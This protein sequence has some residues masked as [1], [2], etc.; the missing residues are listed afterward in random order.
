LQTRVIKVRYAE[1]KLLEKNARFMKGAMFEQLVKN[2]QRDG[3]LTSLPVVNRQSGKLEVASG[4][5]RVAAAIKAGLVEGDA[6]E[7][8]TPLTRE[9]FVAIQL[10]HNAIAGEDDP[11]VLRALYDE[12]GFDWKEYSGLSDD[13]FDVNNLDTSVLRV[14]QP[15][16]EELHVSFL[17]GDAEV[18]KRWLE[19]I[20]K[21]KS[22]ATRYVG[23]Y[24]DFRLFFETLVDVKDARGVVNTAVALRMMAELAGQALEKNEREA[25]PSRLGQQSEKS[26]NART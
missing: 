18:F 7:I 23:L 15:F 1:L 17:P 26:A 22:A 6:L 8:V 9:Q 13:A 20:G 14:E 24:E 5:H 19:K 16:Y 11:N 21:S 25:A 10:S 4:N 2:I 12:L 3:C